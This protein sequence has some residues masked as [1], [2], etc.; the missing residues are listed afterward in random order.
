MCKLEVF[1]S[2]LTLSLDSELLTKSRAYAKKHNTSLN[3]LIRTLLQKNIIQAEED[4]LK[5][6]FALMD[7]A[8]GNSDGE[9]WDR[10]D[11]YDV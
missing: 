8:K 7:R 9:K 1:M 6:S 11:L 3:S 10:E 2:N 5:N 4:W